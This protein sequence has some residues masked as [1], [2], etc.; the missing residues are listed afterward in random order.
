MQYA[1]KED[2]RDEAVRV[3]AGEQRGSR[4]GDGVSVCCLL[5]IGDLS[6]S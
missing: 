1:G 6:G 5:R 3:H 4:E 2:G